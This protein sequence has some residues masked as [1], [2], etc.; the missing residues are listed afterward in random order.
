MRTD[1]EIKAEGMAALKGALD[2]VEVE[3]FILL[4]RRE[5]FDYTEW[6]RS[7]WPEK[8]ASDIFEMGRKQAGAETKGR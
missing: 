8:K 7:L 3:K 1:T 2:P 4:L 5:T 6:Q